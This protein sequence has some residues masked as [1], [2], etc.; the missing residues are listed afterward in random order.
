MW[1]RTEKIKFKI[2]VV[3]FAVKQQKQVR[4]LQG[5]TPDQMHSNIRSGNGKNV[6]CVLIITRSN[7]KE[8][9]CLV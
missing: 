8:N 7:V 9:S 1:V 3:W 6:A 4:L 2:V 5:S